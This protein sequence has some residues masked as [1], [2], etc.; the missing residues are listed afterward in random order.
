MKKLYATAFFTLLC[1]GL[2]GVLWQA[3]IVIHDC[4]QYRDIAKRQQMILKREVVP[5]L[6]ELATGLT[7]IRMPDGEVISFENS[8]K[9]LDEGKDMWGGRECHH[10]PLWALTRSLLFLVPFVVLVASKKWI[11]WLAS[12]EDNALPK[13]QNE[14]KN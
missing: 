14:K 8:P 7:E 10:Q 11:Q 1:M 5:S 2:G 13:L 6:N 12:D 4:H 3:A 9:D